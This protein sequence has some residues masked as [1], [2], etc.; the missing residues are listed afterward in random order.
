M[1]LID[2]NFILSMYGDRIFF[3]RLYTIF[4]LRFFSDGNMFFQ[5]T[6]ALR[7]DN[8]INSE[9]VDVRLLPLFTGGYTIPS[10]AAPQSPAPGIV[11]LHCLF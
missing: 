9:R 11:Y 2:M 1:R 10:L 4:E 5:S 7:F 6:E 3:P 8:I